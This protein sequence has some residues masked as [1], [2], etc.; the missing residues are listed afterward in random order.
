MKYGAQHPTLHFFTPKNKTMKNSQ[1][2]SNLI[3]TRLTQIAKPVNLD[4]R[5]EKQNLSFLC[6]AEIDNIE[7]ETIY[8]SVNFNR[9]EIWYNYEIEMRDVVSHFY[10]VSEYESLVDFDFEGNRQAWVSIFDVEIDGYDV[11]E[12]MIDNALLKTYSA[13]TNSEN[14]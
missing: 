3:I 10:D 5:K 1:I 11:L 12:Y 13:I 7:G 4:Q 2:I 9:S 14:F 6:E 8:A